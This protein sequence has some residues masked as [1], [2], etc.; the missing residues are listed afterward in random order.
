M[1]FPY[2]LVLLEFDILPTLYSLDVLETDKMQ[3]FL[4]TKITNIIQT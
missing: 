2:I 4:H 3:E 1:L